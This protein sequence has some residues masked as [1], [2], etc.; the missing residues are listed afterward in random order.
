[1]EWVCTR[2]VLR[3]L[4]DENRMNRVVASQAFL[5]EWRSEGERFL[6]RIFTTD[7]T[8]LYYYDL[9]KKQQSSQWVTKGQGLPEKASLQVGR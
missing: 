5:R 3:I 2:W 8:W 6:D 4:T 1:M 9:E 7:E